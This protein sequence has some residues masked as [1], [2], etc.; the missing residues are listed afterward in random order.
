MSIF[1]S[2]FTHKN[3]YRITYLRDIKKICDLFPY[4]LHK[5]ASEIQQRLPQR[6]K[7]NKQANFRTVDLSNIRCLPIRNSQ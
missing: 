2:L 3:Q 6:N 5:L 7:M 1:P 4:P